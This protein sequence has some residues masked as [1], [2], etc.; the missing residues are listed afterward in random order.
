M[1]IS[2]LIT[3]LVG[4]AIFLPHLLSVMM[5]LIRFLLQMGMY[6][7]MKEKFEFAEK[8]RALDLNDEEMALFIA[9]IILCSGKL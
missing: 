2:Q 9:V 1:M 5:H 6:N 3:K 4:K 8:I 7:L